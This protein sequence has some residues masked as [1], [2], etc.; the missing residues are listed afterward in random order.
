MYA[1]GH[2][3]L[4]PSARL[5]KEDLPPRAGV[6]R[7][8]KELAGPSGGELAADFAG[9]AGRRCGVAGDVPA[10]GLYESEA[11]VAETC[12]QRVS[13]G[14]RAFVQVPCGSEVVTAAADELGVVVIDRFGGE[15]I[16]ARVVPLAMVAAAAEFDHLRQLLAVGSGITKEPVGG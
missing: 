3:T 13:G 5:A 8:V 4:Q 15:G 10:F 12:L 7:L 9:D 11:E 2:L 6:A 16:A 14:S 1:L